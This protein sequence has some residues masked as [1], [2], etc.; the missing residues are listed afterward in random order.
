MVLVGLGKGC[1]VSSVRCEA[2][3]RGG[4]LLFSEQIELLQTHS[5]CPATHSAGPRPNSSTFLLPRPR[6]HFCAPLP[7]PGL[8]GHEAAAEF[9][10]H[11]AIL[12]APGYYRTFISMIF[13]KVFWS[14]FWKENR[15]EK[16]CWWLVCMLILPSL[17]V[18]AP[19]LA[20]LPPTRSTNE[21]QMPPITLLP[22]KLSGSH[23]SAWPSHRPTPFISL[24][25]HL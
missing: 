4:S 2:G 7:H 25:F 13:W 8:L 20:I 5:Y 21:R 15:K 22:R 17:F 6:W 1:K 19:L 9:P 14:H 12:S 24:I 10:T 3:F 16:W 23:P 11:T 18:K